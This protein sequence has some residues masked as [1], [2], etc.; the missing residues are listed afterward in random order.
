V[1]THAFASSA[2]TVMVFDP[3][4]QT[5]SYSLTRLFEDG[6]NVSLG[7]SWSGALAGRKSGAGITATYSTAEG[8][9]YTQIGLPPGSVT[10]TKQGSYNVAI[11]LSHLLVGSATALGK[12]LGLYAKAA[13]A[14]G[15]P[16]PIRGSFV[17][18]IAGHA[19]VT[20]RP[21]DYFGVGYFFYNFSNELQ[22][23]VARLG[24][25][26]DEQGIEAYYTLAVTPWLR[27]T[28]DLQWVDPA[29]GGNKSMWVGGLRARL[30][31]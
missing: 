1:L 23:A 17:G 13:I 16:N 29:T 19:I 8:T 20:G 7:L 2:L 18:G 5:T 3:N 27:L 9:D 28:A 6:V 30:A 21:L 15:N 22:D 14:D 12:G 10:T 24:D 4:D 31:F 26:D 11:V 25:F